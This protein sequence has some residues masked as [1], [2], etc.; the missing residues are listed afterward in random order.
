MGRRLARTDH[1]GP[2]KRK[3]PTASGNPFIYW[4]K[5]KRELTKTRRSGNPFIKTTSAVFFFFSDK[6]TLIWCLG[7]P[8]VMCSYV[9][10]SVLSFWLLKLQHRFDSSKTK[11]QLLDFTLIFQA[12]CWATTTYILSLLNIQE[13]SWIS[14][15]GSWIVTVGD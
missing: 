11:G 10:D 5:M 2:Y 15:K 8:V 1:G 4:P 12:H 7:V 13:R 6:Q 14:Y 3:T 9:S